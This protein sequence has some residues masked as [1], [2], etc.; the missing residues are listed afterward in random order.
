MEEIRVYEYE[1]DRFSYSYTYSYTPINAYPGHVPTRP[2]RS[3]ERGMRLCG[4]VSVATTL[5]VATTW[6]RYSDGER[7]F[8]S[9]VVL[10]RRVG[11][12]RFLQ[13]PAGIFTLEGSVV[14]NQCARVMTV[15]TG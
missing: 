10:L 5:M 6:K 12:P 8:L 14:L 9:S 2:P 13:N 4:G 3:H 11:G 15:F 7:G 1:F